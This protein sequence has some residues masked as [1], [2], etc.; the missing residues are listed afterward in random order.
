MPSYDITD[1][2]HKNDEMRLSFFRHVLA[3]CNKVK[4]VVLDPREP[5]D[6]VLASMRPV[7]KGITTVQVRDV[8]HASV[9]DGNEIVLHIKQWDASLVNSILKHC[10]HITNYPSIHLHVDFE[11][12]YKFDLSEGLL[13]KFKGLRIVGSQKHMLVARETLHFRPK[14]T[15]LT[16]DGITVAGETLVALSKANE[17]C[18]LP[19]LS[20]LSFIKCTGV[21]S[22]LQWLFQTP[23]KKLKYLNLCRTEIEFLDLQALVHCSVL[24]HV[25]SLILSS[26]DLGTATNT[27][28]NKLFQSRF[29]RKISVLFLDN[30]TETNNN[31]FKEALNEFQI[32]NLITLGLR[33]IF[34]LNSIEFEDFPL[35]TV[36]LQKCLAEYPEYI[37]TAE[38]L[39]ELNLRTLDISSS[40]DIDCH[41]ST[42]LHYQFPVLTSLILSNCGLVSRDLRSLAQ[43]NAEGRLPELKYLDISKNHAELRYMFCDECKWNQLLTLD[44]SKTHGGYVYEQVRP[45]YF[46][47][48]QEIRFSQYYRWH[49]GVSW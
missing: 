13:D 48:L 46:T 21:K 40:S 6:W 38:I 5:V 7:L 28:I 9:I 14:L 10:S 33:Q 19:C 20:H 31:I 16:F 35:E 15:A 36:V 11:E 37:D 29:W 45:G 24:P 44:I 3:K 43:A 30:T 39:G 47:S 2:Y 4:V 41:L 26:V 22:H 17:T 12:K 8:L 27:D 42:L 1:A 49:K 34:E 32:P 23:W 18:S 25:T